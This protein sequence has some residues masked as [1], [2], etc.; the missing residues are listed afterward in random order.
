[1]VLM[2]ICVHVL[3][4]E[5][6]VEAAKT[7]KPKPAAAA[8]TKVNTS[9]SKDEFPT[10]AATASP[11]APAALESPVSSPADTNE[12]TPTASA[13]AD[14]TDASAAL[15]KKQRKQRA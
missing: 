9:I 14:D 2:I 1:M 11:P 13:V 5:Q 10:L 3:Q 7:S 4:K 8:E 12:A 15:G 6:S